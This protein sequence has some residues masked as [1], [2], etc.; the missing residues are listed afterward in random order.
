MAS[1]IKLVNAEVLD[2]NQS[3]NF[4]GNAYQ[5]GRT[6]NLS[7]TAFMYPI[8]AGGNFPSEGDKFETVNDLQKDHIEELLATGF[9]DRIEISGDTPQIIDNVKIL[10]YSFPTSQGALENKINLLKVSMSLEYY[11]AFD[12]RSFLSEADKEIYDNI[13]FLDPS[14]YAQYFQ[15]FSET[16][17]FSITESYELS[18]THNFQFSLRPSSKA[19]IDLVQKAKDLVWYVFAIQA[20]KVGYIDD[21]YKNFIREASE[22]GKFTESYDSINNAYSFSRSVALKNEAH[23][24]SQKKEKWSAQKNYTIAVD[25]NG[26]VT[27]TEAGTVEGR[28]GLSP[29]EVA[30]NLYKNAYDGFLELTKDTSTMRSRCQVLLEDFVKKKPDWVQG[31]GEW[32]T[33][34]DLSKNYINFGKTINRMAGIIDYTVSF[35]T[36]PRMHDEAIFDYTISATKNEQ[37]VTEVVESGSITPYFTNK[38]ELFS[39]VGKDTAKE[40]YDKLTTS[41]KVLDRVKPLYNSVRDSSRS[42]YSLSHP[43]NLISKTISFDAYGVQI[44]YSFTYSDDKT[45][46]NQT[47]IRKFEKK[48]SYEMPVI[49][50]QSFLAPNWKTTNFDA[51]QSSIGKKSV[52]IDCVLKRDPSANIIN[53]QSHADYIKKATDSVFSSMNEEAEKSAF[54]KATQ[55]TKDNFNFYPSALTY[56]INNDYAFSYQVGL[57]FIDRRGVSPTPLKY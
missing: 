48:E 21:R 19:N 28:L 27:I 33:S 18:Y 17:S 4:V 32:S 22:R 7:I 39:N 1:D 54:V 30:E 50:R 44:T 8:I 11:E 40:K 37:N 45:L 26:I 57:D 49:N 46:R 34:D 55:A 36:N 25:N 23:K 47:Y 2:Y 12:N 41:V 20:P 15:S 43:K 10:S 3:S 24:V 29:I 14:I 52:N 51:D 9:V 13:G 16:F 42:A 53:A 56:N 5:F 38:N 6:I 35:T 31:E